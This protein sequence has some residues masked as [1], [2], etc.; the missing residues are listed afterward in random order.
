MASRMQAVDKQDSS[1][2]VY[3]PLELIVASFVRATSSGEH[4]RVDQIIIVIIVIVSGHVAMQ[5]MSTGVRSNGIQNAVQTGFKNTAHLPR[6]FCSWCACALAQTLRR[7]PSSRMS[8][9]FGGC[10]VPELPCG[11]WADDSHR[12]ACMLHCIMILQEFA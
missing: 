5:S 10:L 2:C 1:S 12:D 9:C 4:P 8:S 11:C 3:G 7:P 6:M